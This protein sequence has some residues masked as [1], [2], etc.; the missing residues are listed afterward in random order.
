MAL[1][2]ETLTRHELNGLRV[3]VVDAANPDLVGIA[4]RV[5]V[6]TMQTLHVDVSDTSNGGTRVCQVP[7]QGATLQ[8]EIPSRDTRPTRTDEAADAEKASGTTSK[9][10]SETAGGLEASQSGRP[11]E[12]SSAASRTSSGNCEGVAYVTVDG[13]RLLS[14][15]AL[16]TE[17]AGDTT[18]R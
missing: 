11:A 13:T 1:T 3:E 15:P 18:W 4:G 9:L 8:F 14:R 2:P 6:E 16:R 5:V 12:D 17:K 7:K 10:R